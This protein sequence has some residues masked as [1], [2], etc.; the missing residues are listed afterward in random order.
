MKGL[1]YILMCL[2]LAFTACSD[3]DSNFKEDSN[4]RIDEVLVN[5][6]ATLKAS[7]H[8]W[9][10]QYY[11]DSR[12]TGGYNFLFQ[13][14]ENGR[15]TT[16][17]DFRDDV[18]TSSYKFYGGQGA[19]LSFD[20]YSPLHVLA[21]PGYFPTGTGF[22]GDYELVIEKVT[23][24][25]V[26]CRGRKWRQPMILVKAQQDDLA[27]M[28]KIKDNERRL[29]PAGENIPFFRN[30]KLNDSG[31]ATFLYDIEN[32][33]VEYYYHDDKKTVQS[34]R[35]AI[36]FSKD[37]FSLHE[38]I[39]INEVVL[40]DF[41]YDEGA[42]CFVFGKSGQ[43]ISEHSSIVK[44][45]GAWDAFYEKT[46]GSLYQTSRD[47]STLFIDAKKYVPELVTLQLHWNIQGM[48]FFSFVLVNEK[49]VPRWF[50]SVVGDIDN[51]DQGETIFMP[52][53]RDGIRLVIPNTPNDE[54]ECQ[55]LFY[56]GDET[57]D[58]LNKILDLFYDPAG[59]TVIPTASGNYYLISRSRS[60][61][62]M[63]FRTL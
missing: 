33:F 47:F 4:G 3:E 58:A 51:T 22:R 50:H 16:S 49:N 20:S 61:Y 5:C 32:R 45:E 24:D 12:R 57:S 7:P 23:A 25:T 42:D 55:Q 18:Q 46:G 63:L 27:G 56:G 14:K 8:G 30:L 38:S 35:V 1:I 31:L 10:M 62:W 26:Y 9:K 59:C 11:P 39:T 2:L 44:F 21:D 28:E 29:A 41:V 43:I 54:D 19:V 34:G 15:V 13:F 60:N 52:L 37:G 53:I 6:D 36:C 17:T 40:K 48:Q